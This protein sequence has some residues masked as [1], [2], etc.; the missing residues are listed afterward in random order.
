MKRPSHRT[1]LQEIFKEQKAQREIKGLKALLK[2]RSGGGFFS[3]SADRVIL[4]L[5]PASFRIDTTN[6][7]GL[8]L[9]QVVSNGIQATLFWPQE[10]KYVQGTAEEGLFAKYLELPLDPEVMVP[11]L[12][13]VLPL[14]DETDYQIN[15]IKNGKIFLLEEEGQ[16]IRIDAETLRPLQFL[17]LDSSRLP[18]LEIRFLEWTTVHDRPVPQKLKIIFWKSHRS[19][20]VE[21]DGIELNP[22]LKPKIFQIDLPADAEQIDT[23]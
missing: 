23:F 2:V 14:H 9:S 17:A 22:P 20:I 13:G 11:L 10:K 8:L 7:F 19:L 1:S 6:D 15:L 4:L 12:A 16:R 21:L 18:S 3:P 5:L